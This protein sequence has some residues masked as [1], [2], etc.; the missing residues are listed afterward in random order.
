MSSYDQLLYQVESLKAENSHLKKE[1]QDNSSQLNKLETESFTMKDGMSHHHSS[2]QE[3]ELLAQAAMHGVG[4]ATTTSSAGSGAGASFQS[5]SSAKL[6]GKAHSLLTA[7]ASGGTE[8]CLRPTMD[9]FSRIK[10]LERDRLLILNEQ[11]KEENLRSQCLA[12]L[13]SLTRRIED[14]PIT[15]NYSLQTDMSRRQLEYEARQL[16][17]LMQERLG[18]MEDIASRH[19]MRMQRLSAIEYELRQVQEQQQHQQQQQQQAA[20]P[21]WNQ[22]VQPS[23]PDDAL[24][25]AYSQGLNVGGGT[26]SK[27]SSASS[28]DSNSHGSPATGRRANSLALDGKLE[29]NLSSSPPN[30]LHQNH[31]AAIAQA[32]TDSPY[33]HLSNDG[34][35]QA[36]SGMQQG[37]G[38]G[39]GG[40]P[41]CPP[42][43]FHGAWPFLNNLHGGSGAAGMES[44]EQALGKIAGAGAGSGG[45]GEQETSSVMSFGSSSCSG[46]GPRKGSGAGTHN[47]QLGVKVGFVYSLLS[48]LGSHDRDDMASTLLMMSRSADSC[49]AMRQSGCI[50]LLIHILHGTDQESVLGNF[51]GS[52]KARAC[53]STAL[54]NIVHLNPD[55]KRRKQEG[56]VLRLLEQIRAYCDSLVESETKES[57]NTQKP[58]PMDH[59]PGP[60][61]AALMKL[62]FDEEHRSAI[63]HLGGLHAIAELLQV[64]YEVH[65]SSSDQYTVTLRRYAGMALTNLTFGDVTNKALL[66]SMKGCMKAL[67]ALLGAESEDLRQ[68][69][70]SV[71]RNLSWRADMASKKALREAG[72]VVALMNCALEVKKESTLKSV[73]S[74]LW[75]LSAHCTENKADICA[76]SGALEFLVSSLTYRSPTRNSAVVE[77]GGGILRNVSSHIATNEKYRQILRK[78]NCLQILLHHLKSSSLTIVSNACGTLWNLSARNKSDQDLLWELGAVSMLKNLINSKHKMIAMGSSAALRNLMSSRPDVLATSEGQKDGTPGLH[79]RKQRALQAEI[80]KNLKDTYAELEGRTDQHGLLQNQQRASL[81]NR[82]RSRQ[83]GPDYSPVPQRIPIWNPNATPLPDSLMNS[84]QRALSP[85]SRHHGNV[86]TPEGR[87][88][89]SFEEGKTTGDGKGASSQPGSVESSPGRPHGTSRIAQIMQEVAQAGLPNESNSNGESPRRVESLES[90]L[91]SRS[92]HQPK[93]SCPRSSSFTHMPPEGSNLSSRSNSYCFG[94]EGGH[95]L[96]ARRSSTESIN[97][98]SS[99]IFPAGIH[100]RLA[101]NKSQMD[102]SQSADSSLNMHGTGRTLQTSALGHSADEAFGTNMDSTTNYSLKY[103]EENIPPSVSNPERGGHEKHTC[104]GTDLHQEQNEESNTQ[105]CQK[106]NSPHRPREGLAI[107]TTYIA[108]QHPRAFPQ[109]YSEQSVTPHNNVLESMQGSG[110]YSSMDNSE[111]Y[112]HDD[113]RPTDFSQRYANDMSHGEDPE[114]FGFVQ[115]SMETGTGGAVYMSSEEPTSCERNYNPSSNQ[116]IPSSV[117]SQFGSEHGGSHHSIASSHHEEEP[118]PACSHDDNTKTYCV[119]GTPGPISRCSSLSSLDLN[120]IEE[121]VIEEDEACPDKEL[122]S[123][124]PPNEPSQE[125]LEDKQML[126][127]LP[128]DVPHHEEVQE[129]PLVF[130]RC[131][132]VCSLSSDDVPDLCDDRSSIYT[133][134]RAA[135]GYVSPSELPDSPSETMPPSPRRASQSNVKVEPP[136]IP[137]LPDMDEKPKT[138]ATEGTPIDNSC[139]TSLSALTIDEDVKAT[140]VKRLLPSDDTEALN[141]VQEANDEEGDLGKTADQEGNE[142]SEQEQN[143]LDECINAAMPVRKKGIPKAS[144]SKSKKVNAMK[145]VPTGQKTASNKHVS[146]E[147]A[148]ANTD[149]PKAFCTE[150]TPVNFSAATSLSDL[151]IEDIE[152]ESS[153]D[154]K[155]RICNPDRSMMEK[156]EGV[157]SDDQVQ[158]SSDLLACMDD[159]KSDTN[160]VTKEAEDSMLLECINSALPKSK[161]GKPRSSLLAK[162]R[163][164]RHIGKFRSPK[165]IAPRKKMPTADVRHKSPSPIPEMGSDTRSTSSQERG[166]DWGNNPSP[167]PDTV[168]TYCMEGTP[169]I[170]NATS[171]SDLTSPVDSQDVNGN[172]TVQSAQS[173]RPCQDVGI[174]IGSTPSDTPRV[175]AV[176]GTPVNFSCNG[177]LSSLSC[178]EDADLSEAKAQMKEASKRKKVQGGVVKQ[179]SRIPKQRSTFSNAAHEQLEKSE[180]FYAMD[181]YNDS[182][183]SKNMISPLDSPRVFAVEGT[184][185]IISRADSLSS[186]SCDEEDGPGRVPQTSDNKPSEKTAK[187]RLAEKTRNSRIGNSRMQQLAEGSMAMRR[188]SSE[189]APLSYAVEDTPTCFSHNSSLSALSDNEDEERPDVTEQWQAETDYQQHL[190]EGGNCGIEKDSRRVFAT[191]DTP[192]CFSRNS[193]LSSLDAES[194]ED[195]ANEQA[196][197]DECIISGM[198]QSKGKKN[199]KKI[200]GKI[201]SNGASADSEQASEE[202]VKEA[203]GEEAKPVRRGPRISKPSSSMD[204]KS[205]NEEEEEPKGVRGGR[206]IYRSPITGKIRSI[207]P[208]KSVMPLKSPAASRGGVGKTSPT[209]ATRGRGAIRGARGGVTRSASTTPPRNTPTGRGTPPRSATPPRTSS[210]LSSSRSATPPRGT[211]LST[212]PR[213]NTPPRS[214]SRPGTP[215]KLTTPTKSSV[216]SKAV[217]ETRATNS[218][219]SITPPRNVRKSSLDSQKDGD[220]KSDTSSRRSSAS[221]TFIRD[222]PTRESVSS[223]PKPRQIKPPSTQSKSPGNVNSISSKP[224]VG[225]GSPINKSCTTK[226]PLRG[227]SASPKSKMPVPSNASSGPRSNIGATGSPKTVQSKETANG[228]PVGKIADQIDDLSSG[229]ENLNLQNDEETEFDDPDRPVL[230][231]QST[232]T[233]DSASL[234]EQT[235]ETN[236]VSEDDNLLSPVQSEDTPS[237]TESESSV[238]VSKGGWRKGNATT[239]SHDV[240]KSSTQNRSSSKP[241]TSSKIAVKRTMPRTVASTASVVNRRGNSPARSESPSRMSSTSQRSESPS[242]HS[243]SSQ[244]QS[245]VTRQRIA[246]QTK[247]TPSASRNGSPA[248]KVNT[249]LQKTGSVGQRTASPARPKTNSGASSGRLNSPKPAASRSSSTPA[250]TS[251]PS[252]RTSISSV[253][254]GSPSSKPTVTSSAKPVC[255]P[256]RGAGQKP[257]SRPSSAEGGRSPALKSSPHQSTSAPQ[258]PSKFGTFTKKKGSTDIEIAP[259]DAED[260]EKEETNSGFRSDQSEAKG[261]NRKSNLCKELS[262]PV[263]N[264][265]GKITSPSRETADGDGI[266]MK[267]AEGD[268]SAKE[269]TASSIQS[270]SRHSSSYSLSSVSTNHQIA[271]LSRQKSAQPELGTTDRLPVVSAKKNIFPSLNKNSN[272]KSSS[273]SSIDSSKSGGKSTPKLSSKQKHEKDGAGDVKK[274]EKKAEKKRF[275]FL[276]LKIGG[277]K[278]ESDSEGKEKTKGFFSKKEKKSPKNLKSDE[279]KRTASESSGEQMLPSPPIAELEPELDICGADLH[280]D[281]RLDEL[282]GWDS[283]N[284]ID[285]EVMPDEFVEWDSGSDIMKEEMPEEFIES[286]SEV[287]TDATTPI[288]PGLVSNPR[289]G[290][291][292]EYPNGQ[293]GDF[294]SNSESGGQTPNGLSGDLVSPVNNTH[295]AAVEEQYFCSENRLNS[296]IRIGNDSKNDVNDTVGEGELGYS[297]RRAQNQRSRSMSDTMG[298]HSPHR[299]QRLKLPQKP[300]GVHRSDTSPSSNV[301]PVLVSPYNYSPN[302]NRK[303]ETDT[304]CSSFGGGF[305]KDDSSRS[306]SEVVSPTGSTRV[307]T[308]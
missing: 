106:C 134:S 90:R 110:M 268:S 285:K 15:D 172:I 89:H 54:H 42:N 67:V 250:R 192:V 197:L 65:G 211:G 113:E 281:R 108:S 272:S 225:R 279:K 1:L 176:E 258:T 254:T 199:V 69:A 84:Q 188:L 170:S 288:S 31:P 146:F 5:S 27:R 101:H 48:M 278:S 228:K 183:I 221:S 114:R 2:K 301:I 293:L 128:S 166:Q 296:F 142:F 204:E 186:L 191:E 3:E 9:F 39:G 132:S 51:R 79:V 287:D 174:S 68:V 95:G 78:H 63:C 116:E 149:A 273:K 32:V 294:S 303:G 171:L 234:P 200:N 177:S 276:K 6:A 257:S 86:H 138:Y 135:S 187:E 252:S 112:S 229:V 56:R 165:G 189:E 28:H 77:N 81:R 297:H 16:R 295:S 123:T 82:H 299:P 208:P 242:R 280:F 151:S 194:V 20:A 36:G 136:N 41:P 178:E 277:K 160:S 223:I 259:D 292:P 62:S 49:L 275:S 245:S 274:S 300:F 185:G 190:G 306:S 21:A 154:G 83:S 182:D 100:E 105:P 175:F 4:M 263:K 198:P 153:G 251:S 43:F 129:T 47:T 57:A 29:L 22:G 8:A 298:E 305:Q 94:F 37:Q 227:R 231:K 140:V 217:S 155:L 18:S 244:S 85:S 148:N 92:G 284:D 180:K 19:R 161:S 97:S 271:S 88:E 33:I 210:P 26:S 72:A 150:D 125:K 121:K 283:D 157:E 173:Q 156:P 253:R 107:A 247:T 201:I 214:G 104:D 50:P 164:P 233:K 58:L 23:L 193:S 159:A 75:N 122:Q 71:L 102:H 91:Q 87:E 205:V 241:Q 196:L 168:T 38:S 162:H 64:D 70:A 96:G 141:D 308:V 46:T 145:K 181:N 127:Q 270:S 232:F 184:P 14:L 261:G 218:A 115:T 203:E 118:P 73:L 167:P 220:S 10:E 206:K 55:E 44:M 267:R 222:S 266:W 59:N 216:G 236:P 93:P 255:T 40:A 117:V 307:T 238:G 66:C 11:A 219:R 195:T 265:G 286:C 207:T 289:A 212:P 25:L 290:H 202:L 144:K 124:T 213:T 35:V 152:I 74:A 302:P 235:P 224:P 169:G 137:K 126:L 215:S 264:C 109:Q 103:S 260:T 133:N 269:S 291:H 282:E 45:N 13:Q 209:V 98:I 237:V 230:L 226:T 76:V 53:A 119:E 246:S 99:D 158:S 163:S 131:S 256:S 80:D 7:I 262:I 52:Q 111:P 239:A 143:L 60:A 248:G 139:A 179:Q 34:S 61:M 24:R 120:D 17:E 147:K 12:Q 130:S 240:K 304:N 249:G 30:G 243:T